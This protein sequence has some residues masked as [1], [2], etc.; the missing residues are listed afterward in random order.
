MSSSAE[1]LHPDQ[2]VEVA[3]ALAA[4]VNS[5][6]DAVIAKTIEGI[7]TVWNDGAA[8][9]YGHSADDMIGRSIEEIIPVEALAEERARHARVA[10][11]VAESGY[12]CMR[13]RVDGRP[14]EVVMSMSPVRDPSG[15]V[16]GVATISRPVS[17]EERDAA[18]FASLLEAAPDAILCVDPRGIIAT[19]NAQVTRM[20]GYQREELLGAP[21]EVLLPE[22]LRSSHAAHRSRFLRDPQ[23]RTM[24]VG[25]SLSGRRRDG[26]VF[27][28]EVS[29]A[30]DRTGV[31]TMVI[32]AVRDMTEQRLV[33]RDARE[34]ETRLRQLA[35]SLDTVFI[36]KQLDPPAYLYVSPGCRTVLGLDPEAL[37]ASTDLLRVMVH[38]EDRERVA[39]S[40]LA[41][42]L[43]GRPAKSEHRIV[44]PDGQI[45]WVRLVSTPVPN[46][47]GPPERNVI[48]VEDISE[49]VNAASALQEAEAAAR[50]ANQAKSHFLSRMSHELRTPLNAVLGFGQLL[51]IS[52]E[53]TKDVDA[54]AQILKGGRHLLHLIDDVLDISRIEAGEM[55]I[56]IEP[57]PIARLVEESMQLMAPL[58]ERAGIRLVEA[59]EVADV[60]VL[61]DGQR[62]RQI[63]LN[64][65]S[66]AVKYNRPGGKVWIEGHADDVQVAITVH[67]DG[68]GINADLLDRLFTPFDRLG[69]ETRGIDGTGIGLALTRSLAELMGGS[70]TVDSTPGQGSAFTV[71][72]PRAQH[73][74][75]PDRFSDGSTQNEAGT[76][77][78]AA[79]SRTLLYIEDNEP[80]VRVIEHLLKLRPEWHLIHACLGRLGI[81]MAQAHLPELV[82]LDLHLPDCSGTTVLTELKN[83]PHTSALPVVIVTADATTG[84]S[85]RLLEAGADH[86]LTK[87]LDLT[88]VLAVLDSNA[89]TATTG[90]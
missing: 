75:A 66:N 81:E 70:V 47:H 30:P 50:T 86:Y 14:V 48:N 12:R 79:G 17:A 23:I 87:P 74:S 88:D 54:V 82:F 83:N 2:P 63:L 90:R 25:L 51:E 72:L 38:P 27:P 19:V 13:L 69:A 65:L 64:L 36:L 68:P 15:Q 34:N 67:D 78:I 77:A 33:E 56:A 26:S 53:D 84:Q 22:Q 42:S 8:T 44:T 11:G 62:L 58:A 57:V 18:R 39:T 89:H 37:I 61:A 59:V 45:R 6:Q 31:E 32:A 60:Q 55:S 5:S 71:D 49:R 41:A 3:L 24:G 85:K 10:G 7:I 28:V 1:Q 73:L 46:S 29:L 4:I 20:F 35:E 21:L 16:T 9:V 80:N 40:Y 76:S 52:L 43:A